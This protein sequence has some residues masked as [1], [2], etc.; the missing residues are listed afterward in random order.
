MSDIPEKC[1]DCAYI[2]SESGS[3]F[4]CGH[5][6]GKYVGLVY[7]NEKKKNCPL[8]DDTLD[9]IRYRV[10]YRKQSLYLTVVTKEGKPYEIFAEHPTSGDITLYYMMSSLDSITRL[11]T[12]AMKV[13]PLQQVVNQL[14]K[15]SRTP[16]DF[17]GIVV[18]KLNLWL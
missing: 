14:I 13:Y 9:A 12:M 5:D 7:P 10:S 15:S 1:D 11:T 4:K 17:P 6:H 3:V 8:Q 2:V 18:S 16:N